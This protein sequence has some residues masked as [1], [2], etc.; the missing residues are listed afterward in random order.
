MTPRDEL[1]DL[2]IAAHDRW[3]EL[4]MALT[5]HVPNFERQRV[6]EATRQMTGVVRDA[7][8]AVREEQT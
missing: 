4:V 2:A 1:L 8:K 6:I 7:M 3:M 5:D